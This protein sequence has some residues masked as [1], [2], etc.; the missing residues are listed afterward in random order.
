MKRTV[1]QSTSHFWSKVLQDPDG[2]WEWVGYK[3]A[4]GYG[5]T[6]HQSFGTRYPHRI[7][8]LLNGGEIPEGSE[9]DHLCR[10]PACCRPDHLEAVSHKTNMYRGR[11]FSTK[12]LHKSHCPR[13]HP[14]TPANTY[15]DPRGYRNC[16]TCKAAA[17]ARFYAR[18]PGRRG[19][20]GSHAPD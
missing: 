20:K 1:D 7:A 11:S 15:V 19:Q 10:N 16:R 13:G 6:R 2:C 12:N 9:L 17:T 5:M 8:F 18:H 4:D 14:Y 3:T